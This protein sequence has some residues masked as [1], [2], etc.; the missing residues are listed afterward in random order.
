MASFSLNLF[1]L[2]LQTQFHSHVLGVV[3][4]TYEFGGAHNSVHNTKSGPLPV[5]KEL[6]VCEARITPTSGSL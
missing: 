2:Y 3:T 4:S 1:Q 5:L 6:S